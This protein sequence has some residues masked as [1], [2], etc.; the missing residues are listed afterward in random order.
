MSRSSMMLTSSNAYD[1]A[2]EQLLLQYNTT[3]NDRMKVNT[4]QNEPNYYIFLRKVLVLSTSYLI[5]GILVQS[6]GLSSQG[7]RWM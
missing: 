7:D 5:Y 6:Q 2:K 4:F 3:S 1:S